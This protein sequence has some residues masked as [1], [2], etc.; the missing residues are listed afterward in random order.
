VGPAVFLALW[1][2]CASDPQSFA[3]RDVDASTLAGILRAHGLPALSAK[4]ARLEEP[5]W[6]LWT[7]FMPVRAGRLVVADLRTTD[8]EKPKLAK[9]VLIYAEGNALNNWAKLELWLVGVGAAMKRAA[10]FLG[11][12]GPGRSLLQMGPEDPFVAQTTTMRVLLIY[13]DSHGKVY[14]KRVIWIRAVE[15]D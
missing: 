3:V 14:R 15:V 4:T 13:V 8:L 10:P 2:L 9:R 1:A 5:R 6:A 11:R 12:E 7:R